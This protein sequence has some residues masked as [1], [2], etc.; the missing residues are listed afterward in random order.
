MTPAKTPPPCPARRSPRPRPLRPRRPRLLRH[1]PR[2][3]APAGPEPGE[4]DR[5][6]C[7]N[8]REE[9]GRQSRGGPGGRS[10][11]RCAAPPPGPAPPSPTRCS[12]RARLEAAQ[13]AAR[14]VPAKIPLSQHNPRQVRLETG[15]KLIT[16][17]IR[18]AACN[19]ETILAR[20]LPGT[21]P[22]PATRPAPSSAKPSP[23]AATSP[24]DRTL[25]VRLDPLTAPRRTRALAALAPSSTTPKPATPAPRSPCARSQRTPRHCIGLSPYVGSPQ[26]GLS[27]RVTELPARGGLAWS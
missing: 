18:M 26:H 11:P 12:A 24:R 20:A 6:R 13:A 21:M 5:R 7:S 3:P 16:R 9:R 17:A 23:P 15:T 8:G 25:H 14:A 27:A 22:A 2:R 10:S 1:R 19:A 4:E